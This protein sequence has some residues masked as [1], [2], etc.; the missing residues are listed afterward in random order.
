LD[1]RVDTIV[2]RLEEMAADFAVLDTY[3]DAEHWWED[4]PAD[5]TNL[6][7]PFGFVP[8]IPDGLTT[9][10]IW[11]VC[12]EIITEQTAHLND[13][14]LEGY[15]VTLGM[16]AGLHVGV[17]V[18]GGEETPYEIEAMVDRV[19]YEMSPVIAAMVNEVQMRV[20]DRRLA[21]NPE[22]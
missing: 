7:R 10:L 22:V 18:A 20:L 4:A 13:R 8:P 9:T 14:D 15:L 17:D 2:A 5:P 16:H 21:E 12:P 19:T 1:A 11:P 6:H 3:D